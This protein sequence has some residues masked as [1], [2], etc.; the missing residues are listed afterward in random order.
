MAGRAKPPT[1]SP[2]PDTDDADGA[3][4]WPNGVAIKN[5]KI[6]YKSDAATVRQSDRQTDRQ[7]RAGISQQTKA[8][9]NRAPREPATGF[10]Y[11]T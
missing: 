7:I 11:S 10:K 5:S 4:Y 8:T 6:S 2:P 9:E 1:P 3:C